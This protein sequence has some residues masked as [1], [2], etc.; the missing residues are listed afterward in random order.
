MIW[1]SSRHRMWVM[2]QHDL[3]NTKTMITY[4]ITWSWSISS[5]DW[6][7]RLH[8]EFS[9]EIHY[10]SL[11]CPHVIILRHRRQISKLYSQGWGLLSYFK[12]QIL[13]V[14]NRFKKK[15]QIVFEYLICSRCIDLS[16]K[17][18]GSIFNVIWVA[19]RTIYLHLFHS[20]HTWE[21]LSL[22]HQVYYLYI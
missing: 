2:L 16:L 21:Q 12:I 13:N 4:H 18:E 1:N 8:S 7:T 19:C 15:K 3:L 17:W 11:N 20:T 10:V 14:I 22:T 5:I 6:W 9:V